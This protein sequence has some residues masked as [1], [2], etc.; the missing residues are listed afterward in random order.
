HLVHPDDKQAVTSYLFSLIPG[1]RKQI[2]FRI[3][4]KEQ[5]I[6]WVVEKS[7][8]EAG[9][10]AK[11][12]ILYGAV[13][14]ITEHKQT[15]E[16]LANNE[17]FLQTIIDTEPECIKM[18]DSDCHLLMMNRA[19]LEMIE[20]D[21]FEQVKGQSI[22]PLI[23]DPYREAFVA[24]T[25]EVFRGISGTLEFETV[26]LKG[27]RIW[28][29]THAVP[30]RNEQ[31][32]IIALLGITRDITRSRQAEVE[33]LQAKAAAESA[34]IAKSQFLANMSHE[35]RTPMNGVLGMVQLL[36]MTELT[37]E[38]HEYVDLLKQSGKNLLSLISDILDL[39]KIEAGKIQLQP[40]GF[41]LHQCIKDIVVMQQAVTFEKKL[42]LDVDLAG[43]I[44]HI[45]IGDQLRIK[46]IL[47]NLLGN[48]VKFTSAG[49]ITVSAELLD[50]HD[51]GVLVRIA[52]CD[53]GIGI[54]PEAL[55][56][57]FHPFT[58]EDGSTTR[59]YGGTGL[60][61]TITRSLAELMGGTVS[62][63]S[64]PGVGSCFKVTLPFAIGREIST[65]SES[66]RQVACMSEGPGRRILFAEDD[67]I[68][69]A[70][71]ESLLKKLGHNFLTVKN[72]RDCLDALEQGRFDIV[73]LDIQMP[74]VNGE[75]ALLEIRR[76][77]Q[78][79]GFHQPV[80]A[81]TAHSMRGD[82]ER[83]LAKGFDG[84]VSKPLTT[85]E[86]VEEMERV[87]RTVVK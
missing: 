7:L 5:E 12:L 53:T 38:Q 16:A 11:E 55:E 32:E 8:C 61:L 79:R 40:A 67:P 34:N 62:A 6:R 75:E 10:S 51:T 57:I 33:L 41:S 70:F 87:Q 81:V 50:Q 86:L 39:S 37:E 24:L 48:A 69:I 45:L 4:T 77:Q 80:I 21:S 54:S 14:D 47:I 71:G 46:Q 64:T 83:F 9:P 36:E 66:P 28:L 82:R 15:E 27:R 26:G 2:E 1:D 20:A 31:G 29:E 23:T 72:G 76:K 19:G 52:V 65:T 18:L 35:I 73:L 59:R 13:T 68:N 63:E 49:S 85:G 25:Q 30:F 17:R 3:I 74:V 42:R 58:Q 56:A 60:G 44:P 43:E 78:E 22:S 84:Y